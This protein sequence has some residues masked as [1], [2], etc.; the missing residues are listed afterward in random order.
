M[1]HEKAIVFLRS[2]FRRWKA[3]GVSHSLSIVLFCRCYVD[4]A[5]RM[6][7]R[8]M[9]ADG[10]LAHGN[11]PNNT[12]SSRA[13]DV[14]DSSGAFGELMVDRVGRRY[15][16]YYKLVAENESRTDWEPMLPTLKRQILSFAPSRK[17]SESTTS[18]LPGGAEL[19]SAKRRT[20]GL[21]CSR[22]LDGATPTHATAGSAT[23]DR[24][25]DGSCSERPGASSNAAGGDDGSLRLANS[26]A[27]H[28]NLLE[29]INLALDMLE[30]TQE[31]VD[32]A[33]TG[34]SV[35]VLS[36]GTG[37]FEVDYKLS[38]VRSS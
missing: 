23:G 6:P 9:H 7:T 14:L 17:R 8:G 19:N 4:D 28:G 30:T 35:V 22:P 34:K 31:E 33:S 37:W 29:A 27:A 25:A 3:L 24:S 21:W 13:A 15:A 2:L 18:S 10:S 32:L 36:A 20:G 5:Q 38:Q 16:D 12:G 1:F 26:T 11:A